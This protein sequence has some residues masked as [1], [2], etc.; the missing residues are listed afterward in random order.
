MKGTKKKQKKTYLH[1]NNSNDLSLTLW[2][3]DQIIHTWSQA[4]ISFEDIDT[5]DSPVTSDGVPGPALAVV[6]AVLGLCSGDGADDAVPRADDSSCVPAMTRKPQRPT[7]LKQR[8]T[9]LSRS[10][11]NQ[12]YLSRQLKRSNIFL[13]DVWPRRALSER[14]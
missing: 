5:E 9:Q 7:E 11:L 2:A 4:T 6:V 12:S 14:C 13:I 10:S 8:K 1:P 3:L